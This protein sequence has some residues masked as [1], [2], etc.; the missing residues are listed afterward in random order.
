M[1]DELLEK[2]TRY[3]EERGL[4]LLRSLGRGIHGTVFEAEDQRNRGRLAVKFFENADTFARERAVYRRLR[5]HNVDTI[6]GFNVPQL[7]NVDERWLVIEMTMVARPFVL[8]FAAA[9]LDRAPKFPAEVLAQ[10]ED[11]RREQFGS[12]WPA[13]LKILAA[14]EG[15]GIHQTDPSPGNI[16][17]PEAET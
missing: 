10:V 13:V 9:H 1:D 2:A 17:F 5:E 4:R 7:L 3:A 16:G 14:L 8:D 15:L 12:R 11:E 6:L